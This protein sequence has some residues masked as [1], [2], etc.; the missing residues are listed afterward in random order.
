MEF[1]L[2]PTPR[3]KPASKTSTE[4]KKTTRGPRKKAAA[5]PIPATTGVEPVTGQR[6]R[7]APTGGGNGD[8]PPPAG[9][10]DF[11]L[12]I[13]E[14]PAKA[15]TINKYLGQSFRV[16][17]SYGHVRDLAKR[18][19]KGEEVAGIRIADGWKL[20]YVVD[21][22]GDEEG[23]RGRRRSAA[24]ILA[25]LKREAD[26]ANRVYLASDPD[27]EGEAIARD[28][29]EEIHLDPARTYRIRFNEI[30]KTAIQQALSQPEQINADRV[31]AQE[32][33]R[34]MDRVVGFPLSNLLGKKV[35]GG[36]SAGRVQSVAVKLI[37]DREREIERFQTEEYWR[38]TALL[39]PPEAGVTW[40][41]DPKKSKILAKKKPGEQAPATPG[42][43][44]TGAED[45][46][47]L[48]DTE[49]REAPADGPAE[50]P[51]A[52]AVAEKGGLP[53]PPPGSFLAEL[54][55]WNGA[56]PKLGTEDAANA[57]VAALRGIPFV[58]AKVEQKDRQD[59]PAP[60]FTTSTLQQQAFLRL[61]MSTGRTMSA[62]QALY[63]GIDLKGQGQTALITYMRTDS[64]RVSPDALNTVRTFIGSNPNLGA[65]YLP[66]KPNVYASG[67]A[68]QEAHEAIRPTDVNITPK[69]AEGMGLGG[70]QLRLYELIWRRFVASQCTPAVIAVTTYDITAAPGLFRARGQVIKFPGHRKVLSPV[71]GQQDSEL[72]AVKEQDILDRLDL[73]ETQHFTQP[74]PRYNQASLVKALEKE[75]I[76][77]PSTYNSIISTIQKRGYVSEQKG[78]FF[79]AEI[80]K[81]V[82]DLLVKSFPRIMDLKF[83]SHFE[84][85][86]DEIETGKCHYREVLDEF[87]GPFSELLKK[88][89]EEMA[90][91]RELTGEKCPKCG[92]DM[93]K[94]YS[95]KTGNSFVGCTGWKDKENKCTFKRDSDGKEIAGPEV[96]D[97]PCP[98]CGRFMI[99]REG[100][101]G[102]F[103]TCEGAPECPTTMNLGAD[104][105]PVVT[106]LP[107]KNKCPKCGK[108]NL[109]LKESKAGK[110]YV[111]CP[112]AKCKFISDSDAQGNPV[113]PPDT[114]IACE[115]CGSPMVIRPGW[116]GPFL[117]CSGY[118]KCRNAKSITVELREKFKEKGIELPVQ[119]KK[120][121]AK[122][123]AVEITEK[124]PDCGSAMQLKPSRFGG[125]YFIGCADYPK[126]KA[127]A[128]LT[129]E[130]Q[131]RI[132]AAAVQPAPTPAG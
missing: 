37:V 43:T 85:E 53:K 114:G 3:K 22:D 126:C 128:K 4:A 112:D 76:G 132:D 117:S 29:A 67:K 59:R 36:L 30:T 122:I 70:D 71:G 28:I 46:E 86:L 100:R 39:A 77:R 17:A 49:D 69:Q 98:A 90:P 62:A 110:K 38:I 47:A 50:G 10:R 125:R 24:D 121:K 123:P 118:P 91:V 54:V 109:L 19:L 27:R 11:D 26:R 31:A 66:A 48:V 80:G 107:T 18:K 55:K 33:R 83:T 88:A 63:Q 129:P 120:E 72:P 56:D 106:A 97:I 103:Y 5:H 64:T 116:R 65:P 57:V 23:G 16:L 42:Q 52:A 34:A 127:T 87:W 51:T 73:F 102:V 8:G 20:R 92:R 99:R 95:A 6:P 131:A 35:A 104:G 82:T 25:E 45:E 68:A 2:V 94:R 79:A 96:T 7:T 13:V 75:G 15:K 12:V 14:S 130:L 41:A 60:P 74:P 44:T 40:V 1:P 89:G 78:R 105:K 101:F 61:R 81:V 111:Q 115:K 9:G 93:E 21:E 108:H 119:E 58:V 84:E 113:K 124:C 32:A